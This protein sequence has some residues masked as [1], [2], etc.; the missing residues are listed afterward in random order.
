MTFGVVWRLL[1]NIHKRYLHSLFVDFQIDSSNKMLHEMSI[2]HVILSI[3]PIFY[4]IFLLIHCLCF[5]QNN[6]YVALP[7]IGGYA[8]AEDDS[9]AA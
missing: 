3:S 1:D 5:E 9:S 2:F 4:L 7:F 6:K 8:S